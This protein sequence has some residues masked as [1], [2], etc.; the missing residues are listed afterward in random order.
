M[1]GMN[2]RVHIEKGEH[3]AHVILSR[4][5]KYNALDMQA[6]EELMAAGEAI[7]VDS[8]VRAVVLSGEGDNFCAGLDLASFAGELATAENFSER[9]LKLAAGEKANFFQK[10]AY[11]WKELNVPVIAALD[12]VVY[13]GGCQI[14]LA[15]DIRIASP[16]TRMSVMEIKWGLIPDMAITQTLPQLVRQDVAMELVLTGRIVD[17]EEA[18]AIG[19]VTRL[20]EN[21]VRAAMELAKQIA[22]RSPDA[23]SRAKRL[24]QTGWSLDAAQGLRLEATLQ[25]EIM[26]RPNQLEAVVSNR[27]KRE[28]VFQ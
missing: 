20:A 19:L 18:L 27:E 16:K 26:A 21:P 25:A 5:K 9:A 14:A 2:A 6:F 11:V 22:A 24:L 13:G 7:K 1:S 10:P 8:S 4:P 3:V 28:P 23:T 17:A 12:G 15:A